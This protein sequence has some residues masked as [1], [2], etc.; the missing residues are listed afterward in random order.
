M[1]LIPVEK[2]EDFSLAEQ[3]IIPHEET[4]VS[5]AS[6]VRRKSDK[7]IFITSSEKPVV[8]GPS[9]GSGTAT[10][11]I[12]GILNLDS[13][14]YHCIPDPALIDENELSE[15]LHYFI[16][17]QIRCISGEKKAT[18][19]PPRWGLSSSWRGRVGAGLVA[20]RPP[21]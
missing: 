4:C 2:P 1:T 5:L 3:F 14:I 7:L 20:A 19:R 9:T 6:L 15:N 17:K 16:K 8:A 12:L 21:Q 18:D 10:T 13:T 11:N